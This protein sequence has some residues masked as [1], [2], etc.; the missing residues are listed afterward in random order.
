MEH[1]ITKHHKRN[2]NEL[3]NKYNNINK[4]IRELIN[5]QGNNTQPRTNIFYKRI[6]NLIKITFTGDET[7][8]LSKGPKYNLHHKQNNWIKTLALEA[9]TAINQLNITEQANMRQVVA[10]K[11]QTII[12]NE[13]KHK[14][15]RITHKIKLE[16]RKRLI[17]G[18]KKKM[19]QNNLVLTRQMKAIPPSN[20]TSE[21]I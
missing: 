17:I 6:E 21:R 10:S 12:N 2:K 15:R 13:K 8:L 5:E 18:I 16:T 3:K 7:Q 1:R 11:V 9:D 4:K 14:E 20:N 19:K